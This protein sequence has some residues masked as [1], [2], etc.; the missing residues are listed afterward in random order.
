M[1]LFNRLF[2]SQPINVGT[3]DYF[4]IKQ[5]SDLGHTETKRKKIKSDSRNAGTM[6]EN[7]LPL[8]FTGSKQYPLPLPAS[9]GTQM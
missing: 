2:R 5:L 3:S 4:P 1:Y 6:K 9:G 7:G 8:L